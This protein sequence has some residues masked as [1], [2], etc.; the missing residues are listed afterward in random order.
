MKDTVYEISSCRL[1]DS[2]NLKK[3]ISLVKNPVG[4]RY[5]STEEAARAYGVHDVDVMFCLE[6]GGMQLSNVIE[7]VEIYVE[8]Y[9]YHTAVSVGL[10][11]H[12]IQSAKN[13]T[14]EFNIP[15]D[16]LVVEMGSNDGVMLKA[17]KSLGMRVLGVDPSK[18][19][20]LRAN[21][22]GVETICDFFTPKLAQEIVEKRGKAKLI[23]AN[24]VIANIP[25]LK[26][27]AKAVKILLDD[28]GIFVFETGYAM[29]VVKKHLIDT[30]YHEHI[31]YLAARPLSK[32]F[33]EYDLELFSAEEIWT[34]GGSLR[35]YVANPVQYDKTLCLKDLTLKE[36]ALIYAL[37]PLA[38][39]WA[40]EGVYAEIIKQLG[41][42]QDTSFNVLYAKSVLENNLL[43]NTFSKK[44]PYIYLFPLQKFLHTK[45]LSLYDAT[46]EEK[47]GTLKLSISKDTTKQTTQNFSKLLDLEHEFFAKEGSVFERFK[48]DLENFKTEVVELAKRIKEQQGRVVVYGASDGG[49]MMVFQLGLVEYIDCF[50]DD[51]PTKIGTY[52]PTIGVGVYDSNILE[53]EKSITQVISV[54][55]RF[56]D[57][58]TKRHKA[59][60]KR[61]GKFYSLSL[62]KPEIIEIK[63]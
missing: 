31:S 56:M 20:A 62:E 40:L 3:V 37:N 27:I 6:C 39:T 34:K 36:D 46:L 42:E 2:K 58:I 26:D 25:N 11:E 50:I 16:S 52:A 51:N 44:L 17:F 24:N 22:S 4:D 63:G 14:K 33:R 55:W 35:G 18:T 21:E 7:P 32:L 38:N 15:K 8:E 43:K 48:S 19:M 61:G 49:L 13:I 29:S 59:F 9:L 1:C 30:I 57:S 47:S 60:L 45:N 12:F 10:P 28:N 41:E 5:C 54:A 23:T 53:S